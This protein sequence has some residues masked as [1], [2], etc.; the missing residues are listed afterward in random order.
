MKVPMTAG[1]SPWRR[2]CVAIA[3]PVNPAGRPSVR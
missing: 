2:I 1:S 3:V